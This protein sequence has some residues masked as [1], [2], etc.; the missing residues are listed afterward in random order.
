MTPNLIILVEAPCCQTLGETAGHIP[1]LLSSAMGC[2][3]LLTSP[4]DRKVPQCPR[5]S[6]WGEAGVTAGLPSRLRTTAAAHGNG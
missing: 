2:A 6:S 3:I 1:E 5:P 4:Y